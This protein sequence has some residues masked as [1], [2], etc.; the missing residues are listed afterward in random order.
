MPQVWWQWQGPCYIAGFKHRLTHPVFTAFRTLF[1]HCLACA[2]C[3]R[4]R[5]PGRC[6]LMWVIWSQLWSEVEWFSSEWLLI[7][8]HLTFWWTL[9]PTSLLQLLSWSEII[10][11]LCSDVLLFQGFLGCLKYIL[12]MRLLLFYTSC[13]RT[14]SLSSHGLWTFPEWYINCWA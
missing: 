7:F 2:M 10:A 11:G 14:S 9:Q 8:T 5:K 3:C 4:N 1:S 13:L 6:F 12:H